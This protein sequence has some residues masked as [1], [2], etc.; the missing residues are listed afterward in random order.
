M[1]KSYK[2]AKNPKSKAIKKNDV[3]KKKKF[4]LEKFDKLVDGNVFT[5]YKSI[6]D[7]SVKDIDGK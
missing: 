1:I 4:T 6:N 3:I 5:N 7:I 2:H